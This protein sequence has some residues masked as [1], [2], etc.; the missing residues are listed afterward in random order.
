[1]EHPPATLHPL[2]APPP[3]PQAQ[4]R[5]RPAAPPPAGL[6]RPGPPRRE[7][8]RLA[9]PLP[10]APRPGPPLQAKGVILGKV[11]KSSAKELKD[12]ATR[13]GFAQKAKI[14]W[15]AQMRKELH[16]R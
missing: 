10:V 7:L 6:P 4:V 5:A 15:E 16:L 13:I 11:G 3:A 12:A 1:M 8:L 2:P 14:V 9:A